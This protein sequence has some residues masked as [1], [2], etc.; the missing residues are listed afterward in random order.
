MRQ[1]KV[2]T[3]EKGMKAMHEAMETSVLHMQ[4]EW[5]L[6][7][8]QISKKESL[9]LIEMINSPLDRELAKA[10]LNVYNGINI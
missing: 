8:K 6:H 1:I 9:Q 4:V 2:I 3:G 5:A 10:L 7:D